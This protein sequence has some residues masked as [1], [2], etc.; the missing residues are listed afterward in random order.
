MKCIAKIQLFD[1]RFKRPFPLPSWK[2]CG[3][4]ALPIFITLTSFLSHQG[5][6]AN[7]LPP[8]QT[9]ERS[10]SVLGHLHS[11]LSLYSLKPRVFRPLNQ[12]QQSR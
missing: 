9:P 7:N 5:E 4:G 1:R 11:L 10:L 8:K 6:E 2:G 12:S 3:E